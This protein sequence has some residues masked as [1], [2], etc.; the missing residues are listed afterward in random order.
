[1]II[2]SNKRDK[3]SDIIINN[4]KE[5]IVNAGEDF[6]LERN[7]NLN[8][9]V[10]NSYLKLGFST[11]LTEIIR[12]SSIIIFTGII[13][14]S[15]ITS[16]NIENILSAIIPLFLLSPYILLIASLSK[17]VSV[18]EFINKIENIKYKGNENSQIE[19]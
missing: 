6:I 4:S 13:Y 7:L 10:A 8:I 9:P 5:I 11:I 2:N 17:N 19:K 3:L 1:M 15:I 16:N 18:V 14:I 12:Y